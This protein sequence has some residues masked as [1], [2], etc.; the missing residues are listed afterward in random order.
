MNIGAA[1]KWLIVLNTLF[2]MVSILLGEVL[3]LPIYVSLSN[4][5]VFINVIV[6][7]LGLLIGLSLVN[8]E[9]RLLTC[10]TCPQ[11]RQPDTKESRG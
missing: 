11:E 3:A 6:A 9:A 7:A 1:G 4:T 10:D 5:D 2:A 8:Y